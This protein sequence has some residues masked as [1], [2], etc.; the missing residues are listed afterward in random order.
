MPG[1]LNDVTQTI[2]QLTNA[3]AENATSLED[4]K[5]NGGPEI[6]DVHRIIKSQYGKN[7]NSEIPKKKWEM[8][9]INQKWKWGTRRGSHFRFHFAVLFISMAG[10]FPFWNFGILEFLEFPYFRNIQ[11]SRAS[12]PF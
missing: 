6:P 7:G 5:R 3:I 11:N 9:E 4:S 12:V 1:N 2:T 10:S 8:V